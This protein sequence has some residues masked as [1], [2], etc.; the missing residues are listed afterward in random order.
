MIDVNAAKANLRELLGTHSRAKDI[1]KKANGKRDY[2]KIAELL[3]IHHTTVST[4]LNRAAAFGLLEKQDG[5]FRRTELLKHIDIDKTARD[6]G[7]SPQAPRKLKN[8][9]RPRD[10]A[11]EVR[12]ERD[13]I[14]QWFELIQHPYNPDVKERVGLRRPEGSIQS[15]VQE[16]RA[17]APLSIIGQCVGKDGGSGRAASQ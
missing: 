10:I 13:F 14:S 1:L 11:A 8:K 7:Q 3:Q 6:V 9:S 17:E 15:N 2:K 5:V 16:A 12:Q 4:I